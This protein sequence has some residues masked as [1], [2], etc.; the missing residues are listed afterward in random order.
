[1]SF[2]NK[3][4]EDKDKEDKDKTIKIIKKDGLKKEEPKEI[5][6][7][8]KMDSLETETVDDFINDVTKLIEQKGIE[9]K[10]DVKSY[11]LFDDADEK[12]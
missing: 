10:K 6:S 9:V 12:E 3:D 4:K 11:T 2:F 5:I 1:M 7:V 8:S